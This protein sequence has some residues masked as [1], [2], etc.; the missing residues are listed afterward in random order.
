MNC[1]CWKRTQEKPPVWLGAWKG[2]VSEGKMLGLGLNTSLM[3]QRSWSMVHHLWCPACPRPEDLE[4]LANKG[5][6]NS[7]GDF[8]KIFPPPP[9]WK[10]PRVASNHPQNET[11]MPL[12]GR[13]PVVPGSYLPPSLTSSWSPL[14]W[15]TQTP[16]ALSC[17]WNSQEVLRGLKPF[18]ILSP[19][20][21]QIFSFMTVLC[22][23]VLCLKFS[24]QQPL[25]C[26]SLQ[27]Q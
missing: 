20:T 13:K 19:L 2:R 21:F 17:S 11:H 12:H 26:L 14:H 24:L 1:Q 5:V 6:F 16:L 18:P 23:Q 8:E 15:F 9:G 7:Y 10:L 4:C 25:T 27:P 22:H 3:W